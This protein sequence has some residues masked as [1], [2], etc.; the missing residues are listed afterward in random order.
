MRRSRPWPERNASFEHLCV[1]GKSARRCGDGC[2]PRI[3][4]SPYRSITTYRAG[5]CGRREGRT[6]PRRGWGDGAK[7]V[8]DL[9]IQVI[10]G[11]YGEVR[12]LRPGAVFQPSAISGHLA[13]QVSSFLFVALLPR[14]EPG[15]A[16]PPQWPVT[17]RTAGRRYPNVI[18]A[19][20]KIGTSVRWYP[21]ATAAARPAARKCLTSQDF[22]KK[23]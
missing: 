11:G 13:R 12:N 14:L 5:F 17:G 7:P 15:E 19:R 22:D 23:V 4:L 16:P 10:G 3:R 2:P 9:D 1:G 8:S 6:R 20:K 18:S 21:A